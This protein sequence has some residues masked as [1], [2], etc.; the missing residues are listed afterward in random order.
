MKITRSGMAASVS[1]AAIA[2]YA[3]FLRPRI[4]R[5]GATETEV[6]SA[7]PGDEIVGTPRYVTNHAVN[8]HAP[9]ALVWPWLV[10][11]GQGRGGLYSYDWLENLL[12]FDIH[13]ADRIIPEFQHL[14]PGDSIR[15]VREGYPADLH[16]EVVLVERERTLVLRT[17]GSPAENFAKNLPYG[18]WTFFLRRID[19]ETTRLIA[20]TRSDFRPS[21]SGYIWN[22]YGLE[23]AHSIME[24]RMMLGIKARAEA[25]VG[26]GSR[27]GV[28][29]PGR[30]EPIKAA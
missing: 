13:S 25:S 9:A 5:W 6:V 15:L 22:K 11:M 23:P 16:Y 26:T 27:G 18:T 12:G 28:M 2:S 4:L 17:P 20:R 8:I 14:E 30:V 10:Q 29:V 21:F 24:R 7:M 1:M 3:S 19:E